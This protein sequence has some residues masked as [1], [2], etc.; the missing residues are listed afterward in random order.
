MKIKW[1]ELRGN[2]L[3]NNIYQNFTYFLKFL[4]FFDVL[5]H[6]ILWIDEKSHKKGLYWSIVKR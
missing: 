6:K 4:L 5:L 2:Y 1:V 3:F